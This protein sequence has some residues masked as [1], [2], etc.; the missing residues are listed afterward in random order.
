MPFTFSVESTNALP[1]SARMI[2]DRRSN[3]VHGRKTKF[4][5]LQ[6]NMLAYTFPDFVPGFTNAG[7]NRFDFDDLVARP[8]QNARAEGELFFGQDM[9]LTDQQIAK[10][11][12]DAFETIEA[13]IH[14]NTAARWNRL[15][16]GGDWPAQPRY[17]RPRLTPA[18]NRQVAVLS[19]PRGY[20]W[21][22]LLSPAAA[23][24]VTALRDELGQRDLLLPTSTPDLLVVA[25]PAEYR[26]DDRFVTELPNLGLDSQRL[27]GA[28]H[29][30]MEQRIDAAS[31]SSP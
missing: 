1:E 2:E 13:A 12:G 24:A 19:L 28:I 14:W 30:E 3:P 25:L 16:R 15:M 26:D 4:R 27:L 29:R 21:V 7:I 17:A 22:R 20:D 11:E 23:A 10:V 9:V 31:L 5:L 6:Y 8:V 18:A